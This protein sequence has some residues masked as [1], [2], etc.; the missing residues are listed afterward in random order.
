L[1]L[2]LN[3]ALFSEPYESYYVSLRQNG[4]DE[5]IESERYL[6]WNLEPLMGPTLAR[7]YV[8]PRPFEGVFIVSGNIVTPSGPL[9]PCYLEITLPERICEHHFV[10]KDNETVRRRGRQGDRGTAVPAIGIEQFGN[11]KLFY[12]KERS[13][14]GIE[15]LQ[16]ALS[17]ARNKAPIGYDLGLLLRDEKQYAGAIRAFSVALDENPDSEIAYMIYK[18]RAQLYKAVGDLDKAE[19]DELLWADGFARKHGHFPKAD[20][21]V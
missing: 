1:R 14:I 11:Y 10:R 18:E 3:E 8:Y 2:T 6:D 21:S 4:F 13:E 19:H 17:C 9:L 15:I 20:D 16:K 12:A 7:E 5:A